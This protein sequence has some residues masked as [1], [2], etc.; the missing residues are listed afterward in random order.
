MVSLCL[1]ASL[2]VL[3]AA[4]CANQSVAQ[5]KLAS[6]QL[7]LA[8][9]P[10]VVVRRLPA[11]TVHDDCPSLPGAHVRDLTCVEAAAL[12]KKLKE[13]QTKLAKGEPLYFDLLSGA[14]AS[15]PMTKVSPRDAF[16]KMPFAKSSIIE[17]LG[18]GSLIWQPYKFAYKPPGAGQMI[19]DVEVVLGFSEERILKVQ[20]LYKPPP[21]L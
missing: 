21:P 13:A 3:L 19:W 18:A 10:R 12:V 2:S 8:E 9:P 1:R 15:D 20:M 16:M 11:P 5:H 4:S 14:V 7:S 17:R 6:T